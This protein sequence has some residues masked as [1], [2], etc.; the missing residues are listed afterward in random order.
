[1]RMF[2]ISNR[3]CSSP[4][5]RDPRPPANVCNPYRDKDRCFP[6]RQ[7]LMALGFGPGQFEDFRGGEDAVA[8]LVGDFRDKTESHSDAARIFR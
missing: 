3:G 7:S 8:A 2:W 5:R 4:A 1:V 6:I